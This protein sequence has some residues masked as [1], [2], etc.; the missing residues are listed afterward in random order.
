M[1]NRQDHRV[2]ID[3]RL[4]AYRQGGIQRYIRG[5]ASTLATIPTEL[6]YRLIVN[7]A[8]FLLPLP[9]T[10]VQTPPHF[11]WERRT[12]GI[13]LSRHRPALVHSPDFIPPRGR[14]PTVATIHDLAFLKYPELL[15]VESRHYY[16]Q[17]EKAARDAERVI[18]VSQATAGDI[19]ELLGVDERRIRVIYNGVDDHF[20][21]LLKRP[22]A[23]IFRDELGACAAAILSGERPIL[24]MVGTIEPRKRH[25]LLLDALA[26]E[27]L[28]SITPRP[29]LVLAGQH[30]WKSDETIARITT[31]ESS[32]NALWLTDVGDEALHALYKVANLLVQPSIDEGFGLPLVEAMAA[33]TPVVCSAAGAIPEVVGKGGLLIDSNAPG[34]WA[35]VLAGL[36]RDPAKCT[37]LASAGQ[38]RAAH[39]RWSVTAAQTDAVFRE[40][41]NL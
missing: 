24:L 39:F 12:L 14:F 29:L 32:G 13:E 8:G 27:P 40:V 37:K 2:F 21:T 26:L 38:E 5:L 15:S 9:S 6:D 22:P 36:L 19:V 3:G 1:T 31:A 17:V 23:E 28:A 30:G 41:L 4:L 34:D 18:A 10:R 20:F 11:R 25:G 7:R 16:G 33:G 35:E